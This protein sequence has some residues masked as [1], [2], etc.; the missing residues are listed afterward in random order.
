MEKG[1]LAA[2]DNLMR[3]KRRIG[4]VLNRADGEDAPPFVPAADRLAELEV[5]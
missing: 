3:Q 1:Q 4:D 2:R 5:G